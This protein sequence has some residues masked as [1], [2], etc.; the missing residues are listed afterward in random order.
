MGDNLEILAVITFR[1]KVKNINMSLEQ[2]EDTITEVAKVGLDLFK[3]FE[4][5]EFC[6]FEIV[7][8]DKVIKCH[9]VVLASRSPVFRA[10]LLHHMEESSKQKVEPKNF[11][12]DTMYLVLKF[13][14]RGEIEHTLLTKHAETIFK[15]ADYYEI[16]DLKAACEKVLITQIN[17]KNMLDMLVMA[18][19]YKAGELKSATKKLIV[20][21]SKE[22]MEQ[23]DWK[24]RFGSSQSLVFEVLESVIVKK[25]N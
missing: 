3:S 6:D 21:N 20:E 10:M 22:L 4:S 2:E 5:Q 18:D 14:Y 9:K 11:D 8:D 1:G 15:A 19:M 7:C 24:L 25:D 23:K 16:D 12:F 13:M 17:I